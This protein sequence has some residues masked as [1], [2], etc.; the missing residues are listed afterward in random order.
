[1]KVFEIKKLILCS[2]LKACDLNPISISVLTYC[3]DIIIAHITDIINISM[4][5]STFPQNFK[6]AHARPVLGKNKRNEKLQPCI[7]LQFHFQNLRKGSSQSAAS[8][9]KNN[10]L[11]NP[12]Q[13]ASRK[14]HSTESVLLKV[15]NDII[16]S[17]D[18]GEVK[19]PTLL[20]LSADL[21]NIDHD[22]YNALFH[23][24]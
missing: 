10:Q 2:S 23:N 12:L 1:M 15:H 24:K 19:T 16:I 20:D 3:L 14:Q 5:T 4:E 22:Y 9:Y 11:S 8:S 7:Q 21:D 17:M 6:E 13:S 18:K